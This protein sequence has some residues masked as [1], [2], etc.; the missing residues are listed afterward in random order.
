MVRLP[1]REQRWLG[2]VVAAPVALTA[3]SLSYLT[4]R[5]LS[6]GDA[7]MLHLLGVVLVATRFGAGPAILAA[8]VGVAGL[9][10]ILPP[11]FVFS[12]ADMGHAIT[13]GVTI[14]VSVFVSGLTEQLRRERQ[15]A[16]RSEQHTSALYAFERLL[17]ERHDEVALARAAIEQ[18]E[19]TLGA[20]TSVLLGSDA[21]LLS[22]D[23]SGERAS[24]A[25]DAERWALARAD[26][27]GARAR[28]EFLL[29]GSSG[30]IG[31]LH[32]AGAAH[33]VG[34]ELDL[35]DALAQRLAAALARSRLSAEAEAARLEAQVEGVR[36]A[37]LSSVSHDL[38]TP[39]ASMSAS[40]QMLLRSHASMTP[41]LRHEILRGLSDETTRLDALLRNLLAMTR[42]EAGKLEPRLLP[43]AVD[44]VVTSA[45]GRVEGRL[46]DRPISRVA[47]AG[48]PLVDA[49]VL[50]LEQAVINVLENA[51]RYS[52]AGSPLVISS[53]LNDG[54]VEISVRNAGEGIAPTELESVF[55]KF[56][57]GSNAPR[58]DGGVGLGLTICRAIVHAHGGTIVLRN[59][60]GGGTIASFGFPPS[61][62]ALRDA[63]EH[64]PS[65]A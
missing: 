52:P 15:R 63:E 54:R 21:G 42:L 43:A 3:I 28:G 38:R 62:L 46:G 65:T 6:V 57:R 10:F 60:P 26:E 39:L 49:D 24:T 23:P 47:A 35:V 1:T 13:L 55:E 32:V 16:L 44:E 9:D 8:L 48:L 5:Y 22:I 41:E 45:L 58:T 64:L 59:A 61:R 51:V 18:L 19:V 56:R 20:T 14:F 2:Y 11:T 34:P 17:A 50:L 40:L 4:P 37:L 36:A 53:G 12:V 30:T 29:R 7:A 31:V 25:H 27:N 33:L